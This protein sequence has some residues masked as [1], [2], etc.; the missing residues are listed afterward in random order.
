MLAFALVVALAADDPQPPKPV[1][2]PPPAAAGPVIDDAMRAEIDKI[3]DERL[4]AKLAEAKDADLDKKI[5][6]KVSEKVAALP[7]S[8]PP[9]LVSFTWKGDFFTKML[10][11]NNTSGGCVSYGNPAPEGD[12]FSG[13]NGVC[14]ELGL[15]LVGRVSDRVEAGARIQSRFGAEWADWYENG[16]LASVPDG[17]GES[18]GQNHAAYLQLRGIYLR[19]APPIPTVKSVLFGASDLGMFN[20]WT[21]GKSRYTERDNGR[22]LFLDGSFGDPFSYTLGI[23]ALPKLFAGP[24]YTTGIADPLIDNPF[25][26]RDVAY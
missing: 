23:V 21:I 12:N 7:P 25:W 17:S 22:G 24:G 18:L 15:T 8:E 11:R 16:D 3:V 26:Q 6:D 14:S 20:A 9:P 19:I 5:D 1:D 2:T 13:D 4:K 10:L